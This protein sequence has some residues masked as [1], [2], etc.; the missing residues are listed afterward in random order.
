MIR[1]SEAIQYSFYKDRIDQETFNKLLEIDPTPTKKYGRWIVETYI[2]T[3]NEHGYL[4]Q[5][6]G[7]LSDLLKLYDYLKNKNIIPQ[8]Y[9]N[10]FIFK[11]FP[12]FIKYADSTFSEFRNQL[13]L[14]QADKEIKVLYR[15]KISIL[16]IPLSHAASCKWGRDSHW[17]TSTSNPRYFPTYAKSGTLYIHRWFDETGALDSNHGYQLFIPKDYN[18]EMNQ[19]ECRDMDDETLKDMDDFYENLPRE[20]ARSIEEKVSEA[21]GLNT[22]FVIGGDFYGELNEEGFIDAS[23]SFYLEQRTED[24]DTDTVDDGDESTQS[25]VEFHKVGKEKGP[26]EH[27]ELLYT[28]PEFNLNCGFGIYVNY[29]TEYTPEDA[30]DNAEDK[31]HQAERN[32]SENYELRQALKHMLGDGLYD[33]IIIK[34]QDRLDAYTNNMLRTYFEFYRGSYTNRVTAYQTL[35]VEDDQE[36]TY[37]IFVMEG[38]NYTKGYEDAPK[39]SWASQRAQDKQLDL[40]FDERLR[41]LLR[42]KRLM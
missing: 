5:G 38:I 39:T 17:C 34:G 23:A 41:R 3:P 4:E 32:E 1:L 18:Q 33:Y 28:F 6:K 21:G 42:S 29:L 22:L 36:N 19:V 31:W 25:R 37:T 10:I 13:S 35:E 26:N 15:D 27:T 12:D 9:A 20:V 14:K 8:Q 11:T 7:Y 2:K 24:G 40:N 16:L 30:E